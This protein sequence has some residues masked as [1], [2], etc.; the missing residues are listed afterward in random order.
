MAKDRVAELKD[1]I[2]EAQTNGW[3][4]VQLR[5]VRTKIHQTPDNIPDA[6]WGLP[7]YQ[8]TEALAFSFPNN[9]RTR[10]PIVVHHT[11]RCP[12]VEGTEQRISYRK[13]LALLAQPLA[14]SDAHV[15]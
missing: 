1:A 2:Q 15:D 9:D 13:A 10:V 7:T 6:W 4:L 8:S 11:S 5:S 3:A 12:W 14:E